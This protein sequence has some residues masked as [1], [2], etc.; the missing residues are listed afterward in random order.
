VSLARGE[1]QKVATLDELPPGTLKGV[2]AGKQD[3]AL[4][5][6]DGAVF[7]LANDCPHR[8]GPLAGGRLLNGQIACGWHGFRFDVRTGQACV[9]A[10]HD[11]AVTVAVRVAGNDIELLIADRADV[12]AGA[13]GGAQQSS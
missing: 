8:G 12:E 4:A 2:R 6:V 9:P 3:Y 11:P 10:D 1:W 5:N 7:A 13:M